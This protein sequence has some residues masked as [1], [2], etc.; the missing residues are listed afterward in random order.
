MK[1]VT[2]EIMSKVAAIRQSMLLASG[3]TPP[4]TADGATPTDVQGHSSTPPLTSATPSSYYTKSDVST[5]SS[6]YQGMSSLWLQL[7]VS[8][9]IVQVFSK[10]D[11]KGKGVRQAKSD[12]RLSHPRP[13]KVSLEVEGLSLQVDVQEKCTD[14]VLKLTGM[15]SY[16]SVQEGTSN[17][18]EPLLVHSKG[19]LFSSSMSNLSDEVLRVTA[20]GFSP[21][22]FRSPG[23]GRSMEVYSNLGSGSFLYLKGYIPSKLCHAHKLE[24][25]IRPF[26]FVLWLPVVQ[27]LQSVLG[28]PGEQ[29]KS[30]KKSVSI[31]FQ[32]LSLLIF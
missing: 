20:H 23:I 31:K 13:V 9:C 14:F 4:L 3:H 18:W 15:E 25:N 17:V 24:A 28:F 5:V 2:A 11:V 30:A 16:L 7:L 29:K 32:S 1:V 10:G 26:E 27:L 6:S 21:S 8:K 19:K 12:T 22:Q